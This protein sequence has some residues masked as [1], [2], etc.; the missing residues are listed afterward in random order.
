[1]K[2]KYT[3]FTSSTYTSLIS[4][5]S[6]LFCFFS[7]L[8]TTYSGCLYS[9][10]KSRRALWGLRLQ[11]WHLWRPPAPR[12]PPGTPQ[13]R[14]ICREIITIRGQSLCLSTSKILTRHPPLRPVSVSPAFVAGGGQTRRAERG[15]G[16]QYF[17]RREK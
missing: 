5:Q 12:I 9:R 11:S 2:I 4:R 1:V 10:W 16:G 7:Q 14:Y 6:Y 3:H 17:G 13:N 15:M 8:F